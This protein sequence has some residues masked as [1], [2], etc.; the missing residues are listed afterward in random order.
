[1]MQMISLEVYID[2]Q[3]YKLTTRMHFDQF[4]A[5]Q[6]ETFHFF[7]THPIFSIASACKLSNETKLLVS[8][9]LQIY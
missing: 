3:I 1:M 7:T 6:K 2:S 8:S 9:F 5:I 4:N